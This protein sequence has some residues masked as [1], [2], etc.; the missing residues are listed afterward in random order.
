MPKAI[1]QMTPVNKGLA[2]LCYLRENT[3][4]LSKYNVISSHILLRCAWKA[5]S[6]DRRMVFNTNSA[7]LIIQSLGYHKT[8]PYQ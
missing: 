4:F 3:I 2:L 5:R 8:L 6:R 7:C 1:D